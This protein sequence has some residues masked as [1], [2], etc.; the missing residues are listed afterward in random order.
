[1]SASVRPPAVAGSFYEADPERLRREVDRCSEWDGPQLAAGSWRALLLPHAGHVYSG[2]IAGAGVARVAWPRRVILIG[3]NHHGVGAVA[4]VSPS[5]AWRTPLGNVGIDDG[6]TRQLLAAC[7]ALRADAESH[8]QEHSLEV[9]LPFLQVARPDLAIACITL[10]EPDYELCEQVGLAVAHVVRRAETE[11][12]PIALVVSSDL[13][14]YLSRSE[15]RKKD[16]RALEALLLGDPA[17]LF[18]RVLVRER[19]TMCG[20]LPATAL[21]AALRSLGPATARIV[22]RGD[23]GD[24]GGEMK[25]VVGYASVLWQIPEAAKEKR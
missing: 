19:I 16:D 3:P 20:I 17:E 1:M 24:A 25:R 12:D 14:H 5:P 22:A 21:L 8:A 18:D 10:A 9:L 13:N 4:A 11:G 15:N 2:R 7:P 23:S 6:L